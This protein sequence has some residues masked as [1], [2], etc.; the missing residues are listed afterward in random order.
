[1][2]NLLTTCLFLWL[3]ASEFIEGV[4]CTSHGPPNKSKLATPR[5]GGAQAGC[6][7]ARVTVMAP[8][9][10]TR[11]LP[12]VPLPKGET[13]AAC[14][15]LEVGDFGRPRE[16]SGDWCNSGSS[17]PESACPAVR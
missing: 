16:N 4:A 15:S 2:G 14:R 3:A 17:A 11:A 8:L 10:L 1:M 13:R 5:G 6:D 7:R 9:K 12:L